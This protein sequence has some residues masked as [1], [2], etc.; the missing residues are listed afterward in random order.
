MKKN[1]TNKSIGQKSTLSRKSL[2]SLVMWAKQMF[3][4]ILTDDTFQVH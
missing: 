3:V 4:L 2:Q 1:K